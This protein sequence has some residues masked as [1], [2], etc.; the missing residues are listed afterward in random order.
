M[1]FRRLFEVSRRK[2][3]ILGTGL[4]ALDAVMNGNGGPPRLW[5]GG[6][7]GNVLTILSYLGW[8]SFPVSRLNGDRAAQ[9][10]VKDFE[11]WGVH[12]EFARSKPAADTPIVVQYIRKTGEGIPYHRFSWSCPNCGSWFPSYKPIL[13]RAAGP[14]VGGIKDP[15][16]FFFDR[17]S[18]A[19]LEV[20]RDCADKGAVV[21]FEPSSVGNK[22]LFRRA[23][24][25][26][27]IL[28]YSNERLGNLAETVGSARLP[29][30]IETLGG[31][32]LRYRSSLSSCEKRGWR[33]LEAYPAKPFRDAAGA[34]DWCSAGIIHRLGH[35]GILAFRCMG[36]S[37]LTEALKFGQALAAWSCKF[38]GARGGMYRVSRA[39]FRAEVEGIM[40]GVPH[41]GALER[42]SGV[43][44]ADAFKRI[45]EGCDRSDLG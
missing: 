45:C 3:I 2:P 6:T 9:H 21:M 14:I 31:E 33:R 11:R 26:A 12:L 8:K 43:G 36:E 42:K 1:P 17:V 7:C 29:L 27:H 30:E 20:A 22:T 16:V 40:H 23:L 10:V 41:A 24:D 4:I 5:A 39:V 35:K 19:A 44:R 25:I 15:Q 18:P 37:Q 28:K 34:G 38:E 13:L 32:G